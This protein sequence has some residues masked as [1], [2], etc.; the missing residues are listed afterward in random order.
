VFTRQA[1][2]QAVESELD[3][4]RAKHGINSWGRHE[5]HSILQE[6]MDEVWDDIKA[7]APT[8]QL[9]QEIIQVVAV[10]LHYLETESKKAK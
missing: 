1:F 2:Y 4:A 9:V 6:E 10:C 8:E 7:N 3:R 5:F